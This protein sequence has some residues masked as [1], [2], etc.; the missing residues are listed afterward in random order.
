MK[1][2]GPSTQEFLLKLNKIGMIDSLPM[3]LN[4]IS[5]PLPFWRGMIWHETQ[6]STHKFGL[7]GVVSP[8]LCHLNSVIVDMMSYFISIN[9]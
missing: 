2:T 8:I 5:S 4:S 6:P 1:V 9:Y 7:S 3:W